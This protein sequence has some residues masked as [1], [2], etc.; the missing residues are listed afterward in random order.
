MNEANLV[1]KF[2]LN[3]MFVK[4][5]FVQLFKKSVPSDTCLSFYRFVVSKRQT[6]SGFWLKPFINANFH[7]KLG[8]KELF[9]SAGTNC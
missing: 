8:K 5:C 4:S 3:F 7:V 2:K 1:K 9:I 6:T